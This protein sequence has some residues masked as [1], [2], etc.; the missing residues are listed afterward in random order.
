M[1]SAV[2]GHGGRQSSRAP[3]K[4]CH[5][6]R[7]VRQRAISCSSSRQRKRSA[8]QRSWQLRWRQGGGLLRSTAVARQPAVDDP[9]S[10]RENMRSWTAGG[11]Q[12]RGHRRPLR[13]PPTHRKGGSGRLFAII[14]SASHRARFGQVP[15]EAQEYA[16]NARRQ[17]PSQSPIAEAA[18][19]RAPATR[20]TGD[21]VRT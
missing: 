6:A 18:S 5:F 10:C 17:R 4:T 9:R 16:R 12:R 15:A 11:S 8:H 14:V 2:P 19:C 7:P 3:R 21:L 20:R 1:R 13:A